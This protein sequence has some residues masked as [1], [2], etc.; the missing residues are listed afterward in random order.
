VGLCDDNFEFHPCATY[1]KEEKRPENGD[2]GFD[3]DSMDL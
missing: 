2:E 3:T 1:S